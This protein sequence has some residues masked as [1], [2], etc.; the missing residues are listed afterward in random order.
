MYYPPFP[1]LFSALFNFP[2]VFTCL[3]YKSLENTGRKGEIAHNSVFYAYGELSAIFIKLKIV[4][5]KLFQFGRIVK[6]VK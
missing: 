4:V 5:R 2:L 3:Q 6:R 1:A